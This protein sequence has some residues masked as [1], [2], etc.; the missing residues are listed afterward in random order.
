MPRVFLGPLI[1]KWCKKCNIPILEKNKCDI[2]KSETIK[3]K[4]SPPGDIRPAL[5]GDLELIKDSVDEIYGNGVGRKLIPENKIIILNKIGAIE[6][7]DE[8]IIDGLIIGL[9]IF[10]PLKLK[11][12]FRPK[13]EGARRLNEIINKKFVKV[14]NGAVEFIKK[15][16]NVLKPGM[17]YCDPLIENEDYVS[18]LDEQGYVI[19]IGISYLL[20]S[21]IGV[22]IAISAQ[23]IIIL[24]TLVII[25]IAFKNMFNDLFK[26][27]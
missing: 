14:D 13:I 27:K 22:V 15:G 8:I 24:L 18:I 16:A 5:E 7:S 23:V 20:G 3:V 25:F 2:C 10:D 6:S 4:I 12:Y 17:I 21:D 1:L 26:K 11:W 9:L 19:G